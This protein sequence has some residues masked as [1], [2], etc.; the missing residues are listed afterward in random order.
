MAIL[1]RLTSMVVAAAVAG[2]VPILVAA[3]AAADPCSV[4]PGAQARIP[5]STPNVPV[6]VPHLPIGRKP[7]NPSTSAVSRQ[8]AM[9]IPQARPGA[10]LAPAAQAA[11]IPPGA[12]AQPAALVPP[13]GVTTPPPP[14]VAV[15]PLAT[16]QAPQPAQ[17]AAAVPQATAAPATRIGWVN[18]PDSANNTYARFGMSGADLG[19]MWDNGQ[20]GAGNQILMAF[21]DTFGNCSAPGQEWRS[22]TLFRSADRDLADGISV[23]D[24]V[25]GNVYAGSPVTANR[26]NFSRQIIDSLGVSPQE[27]TV[28]PTAGIAVGTTQYVAFMSVA[29]WGNPGSWKTNFSAI[30]VSDDNGETWAVPRSSVR[31]SWFFSVPGNFFTPNMFIWGYQNFQQGAF[32][33]SNGYVYAFGTGAGRGGMAFVSRVR[34]D[35]I[36]N[37]WSYEYYSPF[38]W[39]PACPFC[40]VQVIWDATSE[41]SV[42][43]NDYL[44]KFVVLYTNAANNVVMRTADKPEGPWSDPTTLVT[45]A[46]MPGGIYAPYIHPWSSGRDL[47]FNLSLWSTYSVALMHTTLG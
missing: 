40:A 34:E 2:G 21:G 9:V 42:A 5:G 12:Q 20:T 35:S 6:P 43:W 41:M 19:I 24:P 25:Y 1:R 39:I 22:N 46:S 37:V 15:P 36:T 3:P 28:I 10:S 16:P 13:P 8:S 38:G 33:R 11:L 47:Y 18:G 44:N 4:P 27:A 32:V 31:P 14:E 29:S 30:A 7:A 45:F 17:P 23:P 26:P